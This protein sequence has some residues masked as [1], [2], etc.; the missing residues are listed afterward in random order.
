[1]KGEK[2]CMEDVM[3]VI[4]LSSDN[5]DDLQELTLHR[6]S[7]S[8]P[9]GGR[10]R[11]I[12]FTLSNLVNS[13]IHDVSVFIKNKYRSLMDHLGTGSDWDLDR[14]RGGLFILPPL[15]EHYS[16]LGQGD[17]Y[18][19]YEHID[20]FYRGEQEYVIITG[21]NLV[22]NMDLRTAFHFHKNSGAA[23][24]IIYK[25][26]DP[27]VE[28]H[29][30]YS[31][32]E[33]NEKGQITSIKKPNKEQSAYLGLLDIY[34]MSKKKLL[35]LIQSNI[36]KKNY[37]FLQNCVLDQ[38]QESCVVGYEYKGYAVKIDSIS[39]YYHQSMSLLKKSNWRTLYNEPGI[40]Y[41]KVKDE[42]PVKYLDGSDVSNS[43]IANG[44]LIEGKVENSILFR[45][46]HIHKGAEIKDSVIMQKSVIQE[47]SIIANSILDKEVFVSPNR[48]LIGEVG[49]PA[50]LSKK[51]MI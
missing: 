12:D 47:N 34:I 10:Y 9:F 36:E 7:A 44:C 2:C 23:I 31:S 30:S 51:S 40:I 33:M 43:I 46:V 14:K 18:H 20:F 50:V 35:E 4:N 8:V 38:L 29:H 45:G 24:T 11:I 39:N 1:M 26:V 19:F 25:K 37:D 41:T 17:L 5:L 16:I 32:I 48:K 28:V 15:N 42:P 3:A 49:R 21:G 22:A 27:T 6:L 13:G